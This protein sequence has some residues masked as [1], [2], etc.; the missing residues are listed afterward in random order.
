MKKT[1]II[2]SLLIAIPS[3]TFAVDR[4]IIQDDSG[5]TRFKVEDTGAMTND[6]ED[7]YNAFQLKVMGH[8][9]GLRHTQVVTDDANK[10]TNLGFIAEDDP[11]LVATQGLKGMVSMEV[12]AVLT[13]VVQEQQAMITKLNAEVQSL[14]DRL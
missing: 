10:E 3:L 8:S 5:T 9:G 4:L 14:K 2:L 1:L 7:A 6:G 12:V 13:K 11:E